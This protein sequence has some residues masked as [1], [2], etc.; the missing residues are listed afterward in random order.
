VQLDILTSGIWQTTSTLIASRGACAV[1]DPAY[2]PREIDAIVARAGEL[3]RV[4]VVAFTHGHWDHVMGHTA[5][6][7][8]TVALSGVLA[9]A[10]AAGDGRASRYLADARSFDSRWYVERAAGYR[11]PERRLAL[12][13]GDTIELGGL[14]LRAV[15]LPGHSPDGLGLLADDVLLVGD[16]LSPCEIP[17]IDDAFD[18]RATLAR[19]VGLLADVR[20]VIPGHGRLLAAAEALAIARADLDYV[21]RLL[22]AK[23]AAAARAVPL[24][25]AAE[26][27]GMW[28]HH[29]ENCAAVGR[30]G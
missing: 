7:Q 3:G 10:I 18:Y 9:D 24:P 4:D 28:E 5:F 11:W 13:D 15:H 21:D 25:R 12:A 16:Y 2:S 22:D 20:R 26:V 30:G 29:L 8:A 6:P 27:V 17:F 19:L 1:V 14:A 23:D